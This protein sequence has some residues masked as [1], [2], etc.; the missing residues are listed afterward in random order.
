MHIQ[1][2]STES[3]TFQVIILIQIKKLGMCCTCIG[4]SPHFPS[5]S[6]LIEISAEEYLESV[7]SEHLVTL[8]QKTALWNSILDFFHTG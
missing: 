1:V 3:P 2:F 6:L 5:A 4:I 8:A 7:G